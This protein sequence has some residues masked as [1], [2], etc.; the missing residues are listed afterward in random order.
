MLYWFL[1][2]NNVNQPYVYMYPLPLEPP[3]HSLTP[4]PPIWL[5]EHWIEL[6]VLYSNF[7]LAIY[8]TYG[9]V[10][11]KLYI[12]L[13]IKMLYTKIYIRIVSF[14]HIYLIIFVVSCSLSIFP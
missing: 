5:T 13:Y 14:F 9:N 1:P 6:P 7:P 12:Q 10:Y 11:K 3:S 8:F 4:I 2:F